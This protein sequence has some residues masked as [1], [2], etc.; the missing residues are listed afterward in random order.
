MIVKLQINT[1]IEGLQ[2]FWRI[3]S[4]FKAM[5]INYRNEENKCENILIRTRTAQVGTVA[6]AAELSER[7][8]QAG[9]QRTSA[10][11]EL[12]FS[13]QCCTIVQITNTTPA[14]Q[15]DPCR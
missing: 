2:A 11:P 8:L 13:Q 12:H 5:F 14:V 7:I 9:V 4:V 10:H 3:R 6:A 1:R 15:S